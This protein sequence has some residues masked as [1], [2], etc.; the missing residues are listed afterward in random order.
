LNL[1]VATTIITL[2]FHV[3]FHPVLVF[4]L[5]IEHFHI[6]CLL[7]HGIFRYSIWVTAMA[8]T[9]SLGYCSLIKRRQMSCINDPR[10]CFSLTT[11]MTS[12]IATYCGAWSTFLTLIWLLTRKNWQRVLSKF[13]VCIEVV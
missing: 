8:A 1:N 2:A 13:N 11:L 12:L 9:T 3:F 5:L 10:R 7:V 4:H 6:V